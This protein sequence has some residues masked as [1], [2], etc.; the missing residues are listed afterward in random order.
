MQK[1]KKVVIDTNI[2]IFLSR[3]KPGKKYKPEREAEFKSIEKLLNAVKEGKVELVVTPRVVV[4]VAAGNHIDGGLAM[5]FLKSN[6]TLAEFT[7][8]EERECYRL[9]VEYGKGKNP[10]IPGAHFTYQK[11]FYDALILAQ[12]AV[13]GLPLITNNTK[14]FSN[15]L[16]IHRVNLEQGYRNPNLK[17][18]TSQNFICEFSV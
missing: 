6:C 4:E 12:S 9:A 16:Q 5:K 8:S 15:E 2:V 1:P 18:Y 3:V 11:N 10:A 14:H 7:M 13:L 17:V